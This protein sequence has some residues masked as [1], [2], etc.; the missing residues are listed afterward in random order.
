MQHEQLVEKLID[1]KIP[2]T[3]SI[4][5]SLRFSF[6]TLPFA[7]HGYPFRASSFSRKHNPVLQ[8]VKTLFDTGPPEAGENY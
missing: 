2:F 6:S 4:F 5:T 3:V 7:S 1:K 8:T